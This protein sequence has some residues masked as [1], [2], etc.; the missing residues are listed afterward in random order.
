MN[1]NELLDQIERGL[2]GSSKGTW[3]V[4]KDRPT[5]GWIEL[6]TPDFCF[7]I[8]TK[9]TDLSDEDW[10][11]RVKSF[12]H[13]ARCDPDTMRAII[14]HVRELEARNR[15]LELLTDELDFL[16]HEGGQDSVAA[17]EEKAAAFDAMESRAEKAEADLIKAKNLLKRVPGAINNAF[18]AGMEE[19]EG[20]SGRRQAKYMAGPEILQCEIRAALAAMEN[21][22]G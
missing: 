18:G 17:L 21:N 14:A 11:V 20:G 8:P 19:R 6:E 4:F 16:R 10:S 1:I 5:W 15:E 12:E 2:D 9:A 3:E 22:D 13:I 7:G